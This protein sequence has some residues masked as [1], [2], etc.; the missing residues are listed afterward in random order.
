MDWQTPVALIIVLLAAGKL[1]RGV[2]LSIRGKSSG[3]GSCPVHKLKTMKQ[4]A[5]RGQ[6]VPLIPVRSPRKTSDN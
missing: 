3:C 2:W 5:S 6:F 4:D 1:L